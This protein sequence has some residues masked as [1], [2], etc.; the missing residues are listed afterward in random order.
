VAAIEFPRPP[1]RSY[2]RPAEEEV[3]TTNAT[4]VVDTV[5]Y[6]G[7]HGRNVIPAGARVEVGSFD[8]HRARF[9]WRGHPASVDPENVRLD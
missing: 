3:D 7:P 8:H 1:H 5:V 6:Y 2:V 9:E 4:V